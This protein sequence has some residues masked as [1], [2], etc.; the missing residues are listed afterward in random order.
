M[1]KTNPDLA[2]G[3]E[4]RFDR[5]LVPSLNSGIPHDKPKLYDVPS[6]AEDSMRAFLF[7]IAALIAAPALA[8]EQPPAYANAE[9]CLRANAAEAVRVGSGA[10]DAANFL[11]TYLCAD[12]VDAAGAYER[13]IEA[14]DNM[15]A[16]FAQMNPL[17][18]GTP[19]TADAGEEDGSDASNWDMFD[20]NGFDDASVDPVSGEI[21]FADTPTGSF[22]Q[23]MA[24][25]MGAASDLFADP[26]PRFLR[27][28]AG[29]LVL[30]HSR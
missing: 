26:R 28:L 17:I 3:R 22:A 16:L 27:V 8:Q 21:V 18:T 12:T 29:Q 19:E 5:A 10:A 20:T 2:R 11:L 4:Q 25:Q 24:R 1:A 15:K 7:L 13:N 6:F 14:L 23:T 30:E 9:A